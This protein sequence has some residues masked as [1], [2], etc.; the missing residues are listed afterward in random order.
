MSG[1]SSFR[2]VRTVGTVL[3]SEALTAGADL[4]MPGQSAADYQLPPGMT[5]S[6]AIARAWEAMLATYREWRHALDR[7]PEH[8]AAVKVTREK[9]LLPLLYELGWGR[10][11]ALS[12]GLDVAPGLGENS[13]PHFP[14]SHRLCWPDVAAP[15]VW[16]PIHLVG[17]GIDLDTKTAGHTARAPQSMLQDYLRACLVWVG[18]CV[19]HDAWRGRCVVYSVGAGCVVGDR[20][21]AAAS[22]LA[23]AAG[24]RP[25]GAR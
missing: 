10:P 6:A 15:A 2:S 5:I 14:I 12:G 23:E 18:S 16:V 11:E 1:L 13:A 3:P 22:V 19:R 4:R 20:R 17:A 8:D 7:L 24:R 21:T 25:G 9:W